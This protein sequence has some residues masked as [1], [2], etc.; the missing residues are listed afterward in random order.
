VFSDLANTAAFPVTGAQI[1][2]NVLV[3]LVCGLGIAWLYRHTYRGPGFQVTFANALV[4]LSMITAVVILTI[5]NNL[6][7]AFGLVGAMSI[8]RFRTAVKETQDIVYIFFALTI[9]MAAGVGYYQIAFTGTLAIGL[10]I[11]L[12]SKTKASAPRREEYL[13]QFS[14]SPNGDDVPEYLGVFR[15]YCRRH[16]VVNTRAV[17][18]DGERL[19]VAFYV[20]LK[21]KESNGHFV[22]ELQ[23]SAGVGQVNLYFDEEEF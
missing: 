6:A 21:D 23:K 7:R 16:K 19:E 4:L 1:V 18:V 9:G 5:G 8:I 22:R 2:A 13:L 11:Y 17:G 10:M 14:Y 3:A 12:F 15:K 20:R